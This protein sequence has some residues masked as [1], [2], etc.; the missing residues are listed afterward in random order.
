MFSTGLTRTLCGGLAVAGTAEARR[1]VDN[2]AAFANIPSQGNAGVFRGIRMSSWTLCLLTSPS[3]LIGVVASLAVRL[4]SDGFNMGMAY[5]RR[6]VAQV[7]GNKSFWNRAV[8]LLVS[9]TMGANISAIHPEFPISVF[10]LC[11]KPYPTLT[12]F[13]SV[14]GERAILIDLLP[15]A[16]CRRFLHSEYH[17][18]ML[19]YGGLAVK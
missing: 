14:C 3:T 2:H 10:V 8:G 6:I 17:V 18:P 15:K 5:T 9:P 16:L 4:G 12:K 13:W 7:V 11:A 19:P 1:I